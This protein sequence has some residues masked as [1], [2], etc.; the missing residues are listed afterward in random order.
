MP[1]ESGAGTVQSHPRG[2]RCDADDASRVGRAQALPRRESDEFP[3]H[4]AERFES[5]AHG[6]TSSVVPLRTIR[7]V[8]VACFPL[9]IRLPKQVPVVFG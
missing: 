3:V 9:G 1:C 5:T 8:G 7:R 4:V 6:F 2:P